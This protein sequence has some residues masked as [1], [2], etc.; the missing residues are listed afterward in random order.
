MRILITGATGFVGKKLA[1]RLVRK[2]HE[3]VVL[4]RSFTSAQQEMPCP[5]E[6]QEWGSAKL[7]DI[8]AVVHLAGE[9]LAAKRWTKSQKK[10]ILES[11]TESTQRLLELIK[12]TQGR[13]PSVFVST[14][15]IG[16]YGNRGDEELSEESSAG[17]GFLTDVCQAWEAGAEEAKKLGMRVAI[18][19]VGMVL[20]REGGALLK[21]LPI[22]K[23]GMGAVLGSG[24]QWMS[25]IY[26]EDLL[27]MYEMAIEDS[28]VEGV[29]NA[30]APFPVTNKQFTEILCKNLATCPAKAAP[31]D[32]ALKLMMG[33]MST[34]VLDGQKVLPRKFQAL[35]F[36]FCRGDLNK[37]FDTI[38]CEVE[39]DH[40]LNHELLVEQWLPKKVNEIFPFFSECENLERITPN[41]LQFKV[42]AKSTR[43]I[44][45]GTVFDYR[46]KIHGVP[47][48]WKSLI[49]DWQPNKQFVDAQVEGPYSYWHHTHSFEELAGGTLLRDRV[50]YRLP[51]G[52]LGNLVMSQKVTRD[53]DDI[54]AYRRKIIREIFLG[55]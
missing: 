32:I 40:V 54:F 1:L 24:K 23:Y 28:R 4:S 52:W 3:I 17:K 2:G 31:P 33:E 55:K 46:I 8:D 53:L 13:K 41:F 42:V 10:K 16:F 7:R 35:D 25:W 26:I 45:E 44:Q 19:R 6:V 29:F 22:F 47:V 14:S 30:T 15:A 11:R 50:V 12:K 27:R 43:T 20:G 48:T 9:S 37:A 5:C 49:K 34:L 21:L 39:R 38:F 36:R 18:L 51:M